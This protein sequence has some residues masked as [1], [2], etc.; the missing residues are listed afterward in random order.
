MRAFWKKNAVI[1]LRLRDKLYSLSQMVDDHAY[2]RFYSMFRD[3]DEWDEIDINNG[4]PIFCVSVRSFPVKC[5]SL[6][7]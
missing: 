4:N 2:M 5:W 7:Q 6:A 3:C 1:S